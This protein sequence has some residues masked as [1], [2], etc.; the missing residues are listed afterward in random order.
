[1]QESRTDGS[2]QHWGQWM[3]VRDPLGTWWALSHVCFRG[4]PRRAPLQLWMRGAQ[5][6]GMWPRPGQRVKWGGTGLRR[7]HLLHGPCSRPPKCGPV[8]LWCPSDTSS[9][10]HKGCPP[11]PSAQRLFEAVALPRCPP[12]SGGLPG[13]RAGPGAAWGERLAEGNQSLSLAAVCCCQRAN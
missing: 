2:S 8:C 7:S 12:L 9:H 5:R 6:E 13:R 4:W 10:R 1:M 3:P 11:P